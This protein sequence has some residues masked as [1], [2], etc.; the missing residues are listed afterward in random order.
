MLQQVER[1]RKTRTFFLD[2]IRTLSTE[3]WNLIP[4]G[5][6]NNIVWNVGHMIA[7]QQGICYVRAGLPVVT[8]EDFYHAYKPGSRPTSFTGPEEIEQIKAL[9][10]STL[11]QLEKDVQQGIFHHYTSWTS[12]YDI[13]VSTI[14]EAMDLLMHHE[15]YHA[16]I[17]SGIKYCIT[18]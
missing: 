15:G 16:G 17:I 13:T 5:Y 14:Q 18:K 2:K 7:A 10:F 8:D 9:F 6:S 3:E 12:R 1:I 11:L 4:P